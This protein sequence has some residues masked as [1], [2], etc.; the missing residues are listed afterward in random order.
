MFT[1][2]CDSRAKERCSDAGSPETVVNREAR[3]PPRPG[4]ISEHTRQRAVAG[5]T[6]KARSRSHS[7]PPDR[8]TFHIR[9]QPWWD[10][11]FRDLSSHRFA[12]VRQRPGLHG[13]RWCGAQEATAPAPRRVIATAAEHRH[14]VAP[15]IRSRRP[16]F[17]GH[18][19]ILE[20]V[21]LGNSSLR[22]R[23]EYGAHVI[24]EIVRLEWFGHQ[25]NPL[26]DDSLR[27]HHGLRVSRHVQHAN[28]GA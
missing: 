15:S 7:R 5:D 11:R 1:R 27:R 12:V 21:Q 6:R 17:N 19:P 4:F 28:V 14:D 10:S 2:V 16:H 23:V 22:S 9:D 13:L 25:A 24:Q 26:I 20:V 3:H 18:G 8:L